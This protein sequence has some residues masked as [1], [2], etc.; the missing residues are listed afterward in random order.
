MLHDPLKEFGKAVSQGSA[1]I[2]LDN[3]KQVDSQL[4]SNV[5]SSNSKASAIITKKISADGADF[6]FVYAEIKDANG[7]VVPSACDE[8]LFDING[9]A[10]IVGENPV[11]AEAGIATVLLQARETPGEIT[12]L[13][14]AKGVKPAV[15]KLASGNA[16]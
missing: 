14:L 5:V 8:V 15:I 6:V 13:A 3:V 2:A 1:E 9:P 11:R 16:S 10:V 12:V 7:T 4:E